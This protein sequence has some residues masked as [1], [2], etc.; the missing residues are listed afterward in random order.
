VDLLDHF[1]EHVR[2]KENSFGF[3]YHH[4]VYTVSQKNAMFANTAV[5]YA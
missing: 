3:C 2:G 5:T 4:S 1:N